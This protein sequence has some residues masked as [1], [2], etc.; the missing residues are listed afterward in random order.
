[1]LSILTFFFFHGATGAD[2]PVVEETPAA[3]A[4]GGV[5]KPRKRLFVLPDK[6]LALADEREIKELLKI[7]EKVEPV[8]K[9]EARK[10][11]F[12]SKPMDA[13]NILMQFQQFKAP[14]KMP[15]VQDDDEESD[16]AFVMNAVINAIYH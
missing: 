16:I 1:M 11:R 8:S 6:R 15:D 12:T 9:Q 10:K 5:K 13:S 4:P 2:A 3:S 7:Y 14:L